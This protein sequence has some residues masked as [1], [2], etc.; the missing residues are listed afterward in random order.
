MR[1]RILEAYK[2]TLKLTNIQQEVL[3]GLML[4][5]GHIEHSPCTERAR[6]KIEQRAN[7]LEYVEWLYAIFKPWV[8]SEIRTKIQSLITTGK[9]Y[10]KYYFTTYVHEALI[11]YQ[12]LFYRDKRKV[13]PENIANILTPLGLAVWFM[14]DGSIKSHESKGRILNTHTFSQSEVERLCDV[15]SKKF[16]LNAWP[17]FQKDGIQI[18]ISGKS[19]EAFQELVEPH[20]V[21]MMR[22][23]L[24]WPFGL[25][26]VPKQ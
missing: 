11:P 13:V 20:I 25:T 12:E 2:A 14:D 26:Q 23:K 4:G 19:T 18:Y 22:Y 9:S 3:V 1:S 17:R 7:A 8:H 6:L 5:D 21:P 10:Q 15:L 16:L 24:P